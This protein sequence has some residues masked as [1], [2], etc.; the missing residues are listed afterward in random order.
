MREGGCERTNRQKEQNESGEVAGGWKGD[1]KRGHQ[2]C[3]PWTWSQR[4]EPRNRLPL[5]C[6]LHGAQRCAWSGAAAAGSTTTTRRSSTAPLRF[7]IHG[8]EQLNEGST[9]ARPLNVA[10]EMSRRKSA[11]ALSPPSSAAD[12]AATR[13]GDTVASPARDS[14]TRARPSRVH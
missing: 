14:S 11:R 1:H 5:A 7:E 12:A 8:A 3:I 13:E 9:A 2:A 10:M 4:V 6:T